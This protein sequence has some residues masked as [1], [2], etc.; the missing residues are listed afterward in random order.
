MATIDDFGGAGA[1]LNVPALGGPSGWAKA[2]RD[3]ITQ[4][5]TDLDTASDAVL[6]SGGATGQVLA[7]VSG[8]DHDMEWIDPPAG[9]GGGDPFDEVMNGHAWAIRA[10]MLTAWN[11]TNTSSDEVRRFVDSAA[12]DGAEF[13]V[14]VGVKTTDTT[15]KNMVGRFDSGSACWLMDLAG[16]GG[17][18]R[19]GVQNTSAANTFVDGADV[20]AD[21]DWHLLIATVNASQTATLYV[22]GVSSGTPATVSGTVRN[23]ASTSSVWLGER[24]SALDGPFLGSFAEFAYGVGFA[25]TSTEVADLWDAWTPPTS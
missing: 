13:T 17:K 11:M 2:V 7:K 16:T 14:V 24:S 10:R 8:T 18:A 9:G 3:F 5:R 15:G 19:F 21:G 12:W 23:A 6:P 25:L 4:L 22:D 1:P 20:L